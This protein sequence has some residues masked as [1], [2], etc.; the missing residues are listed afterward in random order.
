MKLNKWTVGLAA[1]GVV[2]LA[3][4][5]KAE[6][7]ATAVT[8]LTPTEISGY[9]DTSA[10]WN[11]GEKVNLPPY[12]FGGASKANGFNLDVVQLRVEKSILQD[13]QDWAAGYRVDMWF[14]PDANALGTQSVFGN[15]QSASTGDFAL[16]QAYVNLRVPVGRGLDF[17]MGVFDSIIGYESVA[18]VDDP[19]WTRS[20]GNTIEPQTETGLLGTYHFCDWF[21]ASAG[22]ANSVNSAI[23][24]RGTF[25]S[26]GVTSGPLAPLW[27]SFYAAMGVNPASVTGWNSYA[28]TY[29][30]Y[31]GSIAFTAPESMGFLKDSSLYAGIVNGYNNSEGGS[32]VGDTQLN[33]YLGTTLTT[34]LQALR[35]GAAFDW[36]QPTSVGAI[37]TLGGVPTSIS[38]SGYA[39]AVSAYASVQATEKL[40]FH[41]RAEY[42]EGHL[43][44]TSN[45]STF[46]DTAK[47]FAITAT[48]QYD[49]W[50]NVLS[51]VEF[52]WDRSVGGQPLFGGVEGNPT[53]MEA[54]MLALN[55]IYKF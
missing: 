50:K 14:G 46:D 44:A 30:S 41:G 26:S 24:S 20:Y 13:E 28:P 17:K 47:I 11:F 18:A 51:R 48:V 8:A 12:K 5:A 21:S 31:M 1:V 25:G 38:A 49:L 45:F 6:E 29:K 9:V 2:S 40:S 42:T 34:P 33:Y 3:S 32:G 53:E 16:R 7:K 36:L 39:Y 43:N 22:I 19:N 52:R 55:V 35:V 4:V 10:E 15:G 27:N 23:N 37:T 54:F